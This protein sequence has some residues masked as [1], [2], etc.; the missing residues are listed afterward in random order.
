MRV[1]LAGCGTMGIR[2]ADRLSQMEEVQLAGVFARSQ[3]KV[4]A[5][6]EHYGTEGFTSFDEMMQR[7]DPDAV[8]IALPT[9]LHKEF[10]LK[11]AAYG[12]PV[13]CEKPLALSV[14]E[15]SVMIEACERSGA[16]L[17]VGHV[18][19]FFP[20]YRAIRDS[21]LSS[22]IGRTG[23]AHAKRATF[24]PYAGSGWQAD[25]DQS[26]GVIMDLMIHDIDFM[27]W[28][29]GEVRSVYAM[30]RKLQGLEYAL[31]TLRFQS[32]A[33]ASLEGFWGYPGPFT[34]SVELAGT[35]G[36]L[37][38]DNQSTQPIRVLKRAAGTSGSDPVAMPPNHSVQDPY[39]IEL[40]RFIACIRDG[41]E[42]PVTPQEALKAV[43][44]AQAA[45]QSMKTGRPVTWESA[46]E[47]YGWI[48]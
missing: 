47:G 14:E 25:P 30:G 16:K 15:A 41:K 1:A 23:V 34:T 24:Y 31:V 2:Y 40:R 10:V 17:F 42:S 45:V 28:T 11:A 29:L 5:F 8:C 6:A 12:K 43:E 21:V 33:V 37:R 13:I 4:S 26:G 19:R 3:E 7:T 46:T 39:D 36:I 9:F 35:E 20:E 44:I 27:R 38:L 32:G 48:K 22:E 18:L